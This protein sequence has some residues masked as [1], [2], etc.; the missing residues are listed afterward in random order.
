MKKIKKMQL[1]ALFLLMLFVAQSPIVYAADDVT[2]EEELPESEA[3]NKVHAFGTNFWHWGKEKA[4]NAAETV[5]EKAPGWKESIKDGVNNF[6]EGT[7]EA[8]KNSQQGFW[9]HFEDLTGQDTGLSG[10]DAS[11]ASTGTDSVTETVDSEASTSESSATPEVSTAGDNIAETTDSEADAQSEAAD[12]AE[13]SA[14]APKEVSRESR[15]EIET[16]PNRAQR[17]FDNQIVK[18]IV[19]FITIVVA[20]PCGIWISRKFDQKRK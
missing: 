20:I 6:Q 14:S 19:L 9:G 10:R 11:D 5:K 7:Q 3:W 13:K 16:E 15:P 1:M 4:S 17:F 2:E 12:A 8:Y 18:I